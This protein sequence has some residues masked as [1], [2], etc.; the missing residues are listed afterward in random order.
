MTQFPMDNFSHPLG[1]H[2][3]PY[4]HAFQEMQR[5]TY[6]LSII[7]QTRQRNREKSFKTKNKQK[8]PTSLNT[9]SSSM[10]AFMHSQKV[11]SGFVHLLFKDFIHLF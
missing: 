3:P 9:T 4:S 5:T 8:N 10:L 1:K 2:T 11:K 7:Q 6:S